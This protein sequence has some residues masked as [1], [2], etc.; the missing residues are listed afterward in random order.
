MN[1]NIE[2]DTYQEAYDLLKKYAK[3]IKGV[4]GLT[5]EIG[6]RRGLGSKSIMEGCIENNDKRTHICIDPYGN[7]LTDNPMYGEPRR[8]DHT[9]ERKLECITTL[10]QYSFNNKINIIFF[11]LEDTEFFNRFSDG[12]PIY[13]EEKK[14][15]N[16]YAFVH[17]DGAH[18]YNSVKNACDFFM[19]RMNL[20]SILAF[21]NCDQ[22]DHITIETDFLNKHG[23]EIIDYYAPCSKKIYRKI[24]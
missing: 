1:L 14:I 5:C 20:N 13:E 7:I 6:V 9:N 10:N 16:T 23:F 17:I 22:Y 21:D 11:P 24:Q 4:D 19:A 18:N 8:H 3:T 12:I 15:I 2:G